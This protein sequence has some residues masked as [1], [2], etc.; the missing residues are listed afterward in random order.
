MTSSPAADLTLSDEVMKAVYKA[1]K[2]FLY[3]M[4]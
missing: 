1:S 3:P 4:G 2:E